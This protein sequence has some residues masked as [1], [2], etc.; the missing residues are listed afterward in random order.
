MLNILNLVNI[1][2]K[3]SKKNILPAELKSLVFGC[4]FNQIIGKNVL[5]IG[6]RSIRFGDKFN[7]PIGKGVF[8]SKLQSIEIV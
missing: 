8:S 1:L 6:L 7:Q 2:I 3:K 4:N 5:P